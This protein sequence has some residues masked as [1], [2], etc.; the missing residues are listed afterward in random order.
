MASKF[1]QEHEE[2]RQRVCV[3]CYHKGDR[4]ISEREIKCIDQY[5]IE[6]YTPDNPDFPNALCTGCHIDLSKKIADSEYQLHPKV[7][8]YDA[9]RTKYLR[10]VTS[11]CACKICTVAKMT[12]LA[13][14]RMVKKKKGRPKGN[15]PQCYKIC[16]KCFQQIY[17]GS[18]HSASKC[19]YSRRDKVSH[20]EKLVSTPTTLQR[21]ASRIVKRHSDTPLATLGPN[22]RRIIETPRKHEPIFN[23]EQVLGMQT[24]LGLSNTQT[25]I[26]AQDLR[27]ATGSRKAIE[28]GFSKEVTENS[29]KL[30]EYFEEIKI[31]YTRVDKQTKVS[32]NFEQVTVVCKDLSKLVDLVV[33]ERSL[34]DAKSLLV[35]I[36][37]DGGGGFLKF[38]LGV[39]DIDNLVSR[40]TGISKKFKDSGVKKIF[41]VATV[42]NVPENY[43]NVKKLWMNMGLSNFD[44]RFT[45]ATDLKLCNI[46]VGLMTH[47]SCHPCCWCDVEKGKLKDKGKRRTIAS[48]NKLFWD[49]FNANVDKSQAKH[50]GNVI[51]PPIISDNLDDDTPVIK[52]LPPPE[53]HLLIGPVNTLYTGLEMVWPE[54]DMWLK[55]CNV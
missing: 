39:F 17:Q 53:L 11:C 48:L 22:K 9:G 6:G 37:M 43:E 24:D 20:V 50:Y 3:L 8:D 54:S 5:L 4:P 1:E 15:A 34:Q 7:Q 18:N 51:H 33:E 26:L 42:P 45:I 19:R 2:C 13:Y 12:G 41:L 46:L 27:M 28:R 52:I 49:Y 47:S 55:V 29:H 14:N 25:R 44:R 23:S 16:G 31:N 38:C 10:S 30:D 40:K 36:G 32:E 35:K 21:V